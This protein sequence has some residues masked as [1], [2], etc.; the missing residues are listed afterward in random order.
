VSK[1]TCLRLA[2]AVAIG[3]LAVAACG[4]PVKMG[5]AATT[6]QQRISTATLTDEAANL[7]AAYQVNSKKGVKPQRP[8]AQLPQQVLTWLITFRIYDELAKLHG[9]SPTPTAVQNQLTELG[10]QAKQQSL[11]TRT[12]VSAAGAVPPDLLPQLGRYFAILTAF[13]DRLDG[14]TQPTAQSAQQALQTRIAHAQ[15]LAAKNLDIKVNPQYGQFDY[16]SYSVVP[17]TS[18]LA[19]AA[20]PSPKPSSKPRLTPPC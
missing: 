16:G 11:T 13:E 3:G 4:G 20:S 18:K 7:N 6:G 5:S 9:I 19:A 17:A 1:R 15:C 2:A 10:T 12:Y 14:G 8:V